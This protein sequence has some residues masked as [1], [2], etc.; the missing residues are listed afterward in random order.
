MFLLHHRMKPA[1]ACSQRVGGESAAASKRRLGANRRAE[2]VALASEGRPRGTDPDDAPAVAVSGPGRLP[3][4]DAPRRLSPPR[5]TRSTSGLNAYWDQDG[6]TLRPA[7]HG[8]GSQHRRRRQQQ[9]G[10]KVTPS[11]R[12]KARASPG[13][14]PES[15][16]A[17]QNHGARSH[18]GPSQGKLSCVIPGGCGDD[19]LERLPAREAGGPSDEG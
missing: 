1:T 6:P 16:A 13:G 18:Y 12:P 4:G 11:V 3:H 9:R 19:R 17:L 5:R 8:P 15:W 14:P 10:R 7:E 2:G